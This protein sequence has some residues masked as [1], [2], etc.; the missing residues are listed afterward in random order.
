MDHSELRKDLADVTPIRRYAAPV[1]LK[2]FL[3]AAKK[4]NYVKGPRTEIIIKLA[5]LIRTREMIS[6]ESE[7][8]RVTKKDSKYPTFDIAIQGR[9]FRC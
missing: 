3:L 4:W 9:S 7:C 1:V 6:V 5:Y 2:R 8:S